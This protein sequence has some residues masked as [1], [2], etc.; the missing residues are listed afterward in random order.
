MVECKADRDEA[1]EEEERDAEEAR[2]RKVSSEGDTNVG[3]SS[4][5]TPQDPFP[6]ASYA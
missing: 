3:T 4:K 2:L 1:K 5:S 6:D